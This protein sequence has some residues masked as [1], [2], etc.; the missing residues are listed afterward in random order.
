M[1]SNW[2]PTIQDFQRFEFKYVVPNS[3][4]SAIRDEVR[5]FLV[6]DPNLEKTGQGSYVVRSLYF[7]NPSADFFY[8]KTDGLKTRR[9]YRLRVYGSKK[10]AVQIFF[11]EQK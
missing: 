9:K 6:P 8:E 3:V 10:N 11:L 7:D 1:R 4:A 2:D 5:E